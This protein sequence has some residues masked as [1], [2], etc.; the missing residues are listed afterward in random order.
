MIVDSC[1]NI[2]MNVIMVTA[3]VAVVFGVAALMFYTIWGL[4]CCLSHR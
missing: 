2:C 4:L 1:M 3:T